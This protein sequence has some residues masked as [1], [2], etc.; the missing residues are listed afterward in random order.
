MRAALMVWALGLLGACSF[1]SDPLLVGQRAGEVDADQSPSSGG[2]DR[3]DGGTQSPQLPVAGSG[4]RGGSGSAGSGTMA[5]DAATPPNVADA[6]APGVDARMDAQVEDAAPTPDPDPDPQPDATVEVD[7]GKPPPECECVCPHELKAVLDKPQDPRCK[8]VQCPPAEC[9]PE[10]DCEFV[11]NRT[12]GYYLCGEPHDW[13]GAR[14]H[15]AKLPGVLLASVDDETEDAF[16]FDQIDDKTWIG[17]SDLEH[18]AEFRWENGELFWRGGA[19]WFDGSGG[20]PGG[21]GPGPGPM[22]SGGGPVGDAYANFLSYE[23]N[24][25]GL[26]DAP[27][28][29]V[30]L[31]PQ[32][33][34]DSW[35]DAACNDPHGYVC[36]F[37]LPAPLP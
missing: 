21:G 17:G 5:V 26:N 4:G 14:D 19:E 16:L 11:A 32:D 1:H 37:E 30:L 36:K 29:C 20:G 15:C 22:G 9:A 27:G 2:N 34:D 33:G 28:D 35:A 3:E 31:F 10:P 18:E 13:K 6:A 24:D 8:L 7:S 23:P 12:N 25:E